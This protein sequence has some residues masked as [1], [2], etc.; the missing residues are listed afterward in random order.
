MAGLST[1][2]PMLGDFGPYP[3]REGVPDCQKWTR[4]EEDLCPHARGAARCRR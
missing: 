1:K 3:D 2:D 4:R